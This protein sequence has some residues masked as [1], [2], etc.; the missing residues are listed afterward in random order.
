MVTS[1]NAAA[2]FQSPR[3][4]EDEAPSTAGDAEVQSWVAA[5]RGEDKLSKGAALEVSRH[6]MGSYSTPLTRYQ[7]GE[8]LILESAGPRYPG[9]ASDWRVWVQDTQGELLIGE[10][11]VVRSSPLT[12][13][14]GL[15]WWELQCGADLKGYGADLK[16]YGADL[17]AGA[18][19]ELQGEERHRHPAAYH[20]GGRAAAAGG[21]ARR[22]H[23]LAQALVSRRVHART[24]R[25]NARQPPGHLPSAF[26]IHAGYTLAPRP[27]ARQPPGYLPSGE[28]PPLKPLTSAP[29]PLRSTPDTRS[30]T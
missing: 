7:R 4:T 26:K 1:L 20:D 23:V 24:P 17:T 16:G 3:K 30:R 14:R 28:P 11:G 10:H 21:G 22:Q 13:T 12:R 25:A 2:T 15:P 18:V 6:L 9:R 27:H 8:L 29:Y 19:R 5:L